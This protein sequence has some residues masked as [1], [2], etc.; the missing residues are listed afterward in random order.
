MHAAFIEALQHVPLEE[1]FRKEKNPRIEERLHAILLL[2]NGKS[3]KEVSSM[4][5]R[6]LKGCYVL[7]IH[8]EREGIEGLTSYFTGVRDLIRD[9]KGG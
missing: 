3:A 9:I 4:L 8:A 6:S 5:R 1:M 2:Y 7:D